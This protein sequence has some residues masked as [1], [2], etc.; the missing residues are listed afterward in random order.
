MAATPIAI[1]PPKRRRNETLGPDVPS[2]LALGEVGLSG[3][4]NWNGQLYTEAN[5][6]LAGPNGYGHPGTRVWG[7]W[8]KLLR[9]D[10]AVETAL[11]LLAAP[12]RDASLEV[13]APKKETP[14]TAAQVAYLEQNLQEWLEPLWPEVVQQLARYSLGFG[15]SLH[16]ECWDVGPSAYLPGGQGYRLVKLAQR[17]PSTLEWNAWVEKDGE[18]VAVR[19][20]GVKDGQ[21]LSGLEVPAEKLLLVSW[22]RE[23]N[24]YA[25]YSAFRSVWYLAKVREHLLRILGIGHQREALGVPMA[26]MD[27]GVELT[28]PQRVKLRNTLMSLVY[29][30]NAAI[31]LPAGVKLDWF[32]SAGANKGHVLETWKQLGLAILEVVGAQQVALGTGDTGS[33]AVGTV[34]D[35]NKNT[36]VAGVKANIEAALNGVGRRP[37]TGL[38]RKII[39]ANW[40]EVEAFP[41]VEMS[42]STSA[43][44]PTELLAAVAQAVTAGVLTLTDEDENRLRKSLGLS[45]LTPEVREELRKEKAKAS[46]APP[47]AGQPEPPSDS[48]ASMPPASRRPGM[49]PGP[50]AIPGR[51]VSASRDASG[52]YV[53]RRPLKPHETHLAWGEMDDVLTNAKEA[54]EAAAK[55]LLVE[56]LVRVMPDVREAMKDG[57]PSEVADIDLPLERIGA[58]LDEYL[59]TLRQAGAAHVEKEMKRPAAKEALREKRGE[60]EGGI[61]P[62]AAVIVTSRGQGLPR[63]VTFAKKRRPRAEA[64]VEKLMKA[65]RDMLL[66]RMRARTIDSLQRAAI[67]KVRTGGSPD[68]IVTDVISDA[69]ETKALRQDAAGITTQAFNVGREEAARRFSPRTVTLS[70]VMDEVTCEYCERMDGTTFDFGSAAHDEHVPPLTRC[71]GRDK[72]RCILI[73][74][75][76]EGFQ[77]EEEYPE[78]NQ[79]REEGE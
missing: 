2:R 67:D 6:S 21:Y 51:A 31:V 3:T 47:S 52:A 13:V 25:G 7:E 74:D 27:A 53:P 77:V 24:N 36:F 43:L 42:L 37:Y 68:D 73:Y 71:E 54:F 63:V 60:G 65:S 9:T 38:V 30:E 23:G 45:M 5:P 20:R 35:S 57:N 33:R 41:R 56:A 76:G 62:A 64:D 12:L 75:E 58:L 14:Q 32:S 29:H 39:R 10:G 70:A 44:G 15:F 16:E 22:N 46:S 19:Q 1:V 69:L 4:T 78:D 50:P 28:G 18:L 17:L 34:H 8:E 11:N 59:A 66:R 72:C 49:P 61:S 55:P 40:G 26:T 79:A 48:G